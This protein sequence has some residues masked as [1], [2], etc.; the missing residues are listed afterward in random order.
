VL[1]ARPTLAAARAAAL[2]RR[3]F[4]EVCKTSS[5]SSMFACGAARAARRAWARTRER[6]RATSWWMWL[7]VARDR[8]GLLLRTCRREGPATGATL[9][10]SWIR[11]LIAVRLAPLLSLVCCAITDGGPP[12]MAFSLGFFFFLRADIL[13]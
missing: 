13:F 8:K 3:A 12:K 5:V 2:A 7:A 6:S 1:A 10:S 4:S 11:A 9:W